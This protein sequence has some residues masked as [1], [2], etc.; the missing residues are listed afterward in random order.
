MRRLCLA[1]IAAVLFALAIAKRK[2]SGATAALRTSSS[3][4]GPEVEWRVP[5]GCGFSGFFTEVVL[6][7][8]PALHRAQ[9]GRFVLLSGDCSENFLKSYLTAEEATAYRAVWTPETQRS[10]RR[11]RNSIVIEHG[12]A[13]G[14]RKFAR[15]NRPRRVIYRA[16]SEGDVSPH[17]ASCLNSA[18]EVW[19]P[20]RWHV[21][22]FAKAGV[23]RS[24]LRVIPEPVDTA[25]F[26][27]VAATP[28]TGARPFAF[29]SSFKWEQRKGWDL[30]LSAYW[31]E[32]GA[33]AQ[34][35]RWPVVL[36]LKTYLPSWEPGPRDLNQWVEAHARCV[37]ACV[38]ACVRYSEAGHSVRRRHTH[39]EGCHSEGSP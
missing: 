8:L 30:L 10:K 11:T 2:R 18:D 38:R 1:L 17:A 15:G 3:F 33:A 35:A 14:A 24:A 23:E 26:S 27:P 39:S 22:V 13:C 4:S 25:L 28:R 12:E 36:R 37:R 34:G 5:V 20:T 32:F 29:L 19:V 9:P 6:G 7:F 31:T 21:Q 16:M